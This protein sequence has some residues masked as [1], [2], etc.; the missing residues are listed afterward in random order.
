MPVPMR[1]PFEA[2]T[3][4]TFDALMW[5]L[6]LPGKPHSLHENA[7]LAGIAL[8]LLD[9]EVRFFTPD[10]QLQ[11]R[12]KETGA[13]LTSI[14]EADFVLVTDQTVELRDIKRGNLMYPDQ[15]A[16]LIREVKFS[17]VTVRLTGPGVESETFLDT[18]L[19]ATFWQERARQ[20][21]YPLGW[22]VFLTDG[23]QVVGIPR[24]VKAE[25]V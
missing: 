2:Q 7:D 18:S 6:S 19:P 24:S 16:T 5:S 8:A 3:Q 4:Q 17:G 9:Q 1:T 22:D 23:V 14:R 25:V 15:S 11:E 21:H 12:L 20:M 13:R 10:V